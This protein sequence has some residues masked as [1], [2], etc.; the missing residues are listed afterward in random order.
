M[1]KFL[2]SFMLMLA[3]PLFNIQC[4]MVYAQ[5]PD[6][7]TFAVLGNSIS[8]YYGQDR[9]KNSGFQVGDT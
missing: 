7:L 1:K 2:A 9:E 3:C 8:T 4:S 6:S 5:K